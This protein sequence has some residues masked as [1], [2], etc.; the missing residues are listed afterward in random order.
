[1]CAQHTCL[2]PPTLVHNHDKSHISAIALRDTTQH[3]LVSQPKAGIDIVN[4]TQ[5]K[6]VPQP[7]PHVNSK[8]PTRRRRA[9]LLVDHLEELATERRLLVRRIEELDAQTKAVQLEFDKLQNADAPVS[10]LPEEI[11]TMVF[12]SGVLLNELPR[13]RFAIL[14]SHITRRW[15]SIALTTPRLWNT[16]FWDFGSYELEE[17]GKMGKSPELRLVRYL[18][19]ET[20]RVSTFLARS[21][22]V[23]I[24]IY[25]RRIRETNLDWDDSPVVTY[26]IRLLD[27]H[28]HR[29]HHLSIQDADMWAMEKIVETLCTGPVPAIRSID[30]GIGVDYDELYPLT[31]FFPC[32]APQLKIAQLVRFDIS[33]LFYCRPAFQQLVSL[34]LVGTTFLEEDHALL[35]SALL[36]MQALDQLELVLFHDCEPHT[37][38]LAQP[39]IRFLHLH[40]LCSDSHDIDIRRFR[41]V[42]VTTLSIEC[43]DRPGDIGFTLGGPPQ[44]SFP[45]L[46][47]LILVN[48]QTDSLR[49]D[50]T[51]CIF[52][53]IERLTCRGADPDFTVGHV[54]AA[55]GARTIQGNPAG[56]T[57]VSLHWPKLRSIGASGRDA[58]DHIQDSQLDSQIVAL[59]EAGIQ[60]KTLLLPPAF[61]AQVG[62]EMM[63]RVGELIEVEDFRLDWPTPFAHLE[64]VRGTLI[65]YRFCLQTPN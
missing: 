33:T 53:A 35:S 44:D 25:I 22:P 55:M 6:L 19:K 49:L 59:Q 40:I 38:P 48:V 45:S 64:E 37:P 5:T 13:F 29:C 17:M 24:D 11:L 41:A 36:S 23:P 4:L 16:I 62:E 43:L 31:R 26:M 54:L 7:M 58:A 15:R 9:L 39:T 14:V 12:E 20:S 50:A 46:Q 51:A 34:R 47:H 3:I 32:G 1:M 18:E 2:V 56:A 10:S 28:F 60:L 8:D 21:M 30:W 61:V 65:E 52:P 42:S 57:N 63:A 27:A